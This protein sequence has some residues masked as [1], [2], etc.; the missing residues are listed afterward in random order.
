MTRP[1][2]YQLFLAPIADESF[3]RIRGSLSAAGVDPAD[4]DAFLMDREAVSLIRELRGDEALGEAMDQMVAL[5][6]Q[7][8]LAWDAG[9]VLLPLSEEAAESMLDGRPADPADPAEGGDGPRAYYAQLPERRVWASVIESEPPEPLDGCFVSRTPEGGLRVLGIFG[10]RPDRPGFSAVE[11]GGARPEGLARADGSALFSPTLPGG[12]A[13]GLH[14]IVGE[15]ELLELGWRTTGL[16]A[17]AAG[18]A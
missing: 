14:S 2:P 3:P 18:A 11:V 12:A 1:T 17:A 10:L 6:H 5:V 13:A 7:T 8:Y 9:L 15:E 4:R 16:A